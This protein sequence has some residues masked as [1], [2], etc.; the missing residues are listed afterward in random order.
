MKRNDL[1][2]LLAF[3][4]VAIP[5]YNGPCARDPAP[6]PVT[7]HA[8]EDSFDRNTL[9]LYAQFG[10][11][12]WIVRGG[13]LEAEGGD[14]AVLIRNGL[15]MAD[16]WV[17]ATSW[18]A[19]DGGLVLRF[20][21][22][23]NY[24]LLAFRDDAAP[25]PRGVYN[26]AM[27]HRVGNEFREMWRTDVRWPRGT[28]HTIRFQARGRRFVAYFDGRPVGAVWASPAVNDPAPFAGVGRAGLRAYGWN[29]EWVTS[30]ASFRWHGADRAR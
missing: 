26:L 14:Q 8:G 17:E 3:A 13:S 30:F 21:D 22:A 28:L 6:A 11:A 19:D 7:A 27:Y 15:E 10:A 24:Y 12:G 2:T 4:V 18:R 9:R 23:L 1:L 29:G 25:P 16:G 5:V 20:Q